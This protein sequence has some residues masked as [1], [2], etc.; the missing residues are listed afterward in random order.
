MTGAAEPAEDR[1]AL[2]VLAGLLV[3]GVVATVGVARPAASLLARTR[4]AESRL[5]E[6]V[7][8]EATEAKRLELLDDGLV[9]DARIIERTLR[10]QHGRGL[11]NEVRIVTDE[12]AGTPSS[13]PR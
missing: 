9:N 4:A 13:R 2:F 3:L 11:P 5:A 7:R 1:S 6:S 10:D 12:G 8:A